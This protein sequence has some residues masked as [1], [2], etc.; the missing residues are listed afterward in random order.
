MNI[1][2]RESGDSSTIRVACSRQT[3]SSSWLQGS[4][5]CLVA[6]YQ[7]CLTVSF[8]LKDIV[9]VSVLA[10]FAK[11]RHP[12]FQQVREGDAYNTHHNQ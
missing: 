6:L 3:G 10:S 8:L 2:F 9:S 1:E 12:V 11:R 7:N 5:V 4:I